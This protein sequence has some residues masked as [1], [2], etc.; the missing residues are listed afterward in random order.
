MKIPLK[1]LA[2]PML[3][4][5]IAALALRAQSPY[6][7]KDINAITA[8]SPA[9]SSPVNFFRYGSRVFFAATTFSGTELWSTDGTQAGTVQVADIFSASSSKPSRFVVVN[10]KLLF[11]ARDS[12]GEELWST[13]GTSAGTRLLADIFNGSQGSIPGDRIV[14][15]GQMIFSADDGVD[16]NEL[17]I[18][19]GTPAG[20]RF[21]KDL[22]PGADG[23][24]PHSFVLFNDT[25]YFVASGGLWKT[26][27]TVEGTVRVKSLDQVTNLLVAGSRMFFSGYTAQA[28]SGPWVSDG[29]EEG[30]RLIATVASATVSGGGILIGGSVALG[31]RYLFMA[32]EPQHGTELWISDG[33]TG[34]THPVRDINPGPTSSVSQLSIAV[35]G[36]I[37]IFSADTPSEGTELWRTDGTEAGTVL[38]RDILPG[39]SPGGTPFG[40]GPSSF[41]AVGDLVFFIAWNGNDRTLWTTDGTANGTHEVKTSSR[42]VF[43]LSFPVLTNID[44]VLYFAGANSLNGLEPWKSDGTDAGTSMIANIM[45][46]TAPSSVPL[47]L[48][49]AGDWIYFNAWD[50]LGTVTPE[51]GQPRSLWRSDGTPEGTLKLTDNP[52]TV[53]VPIGR[54]IFFNKLGGPDL[55][56]SDGTPEGTSLATEFVNRFPSTP[57]ILFVDGDRIFA[58]VAP[59]ALWTTTTAPKALA[60]SLPVSGAHGFADVAGRV[61]FFTDNGLWTS[62]GTPA[63]T[64]AIVPDLGGHGSSS[65]VFGGYLYFD[66]L[67]TGGTELWKSDGSFDG[68]TE[69]KT[70]LSGT[71]TLR[72]VVAGKNLFFIANGHLWI[73]DGTDAGTYALPAQTDGPIAAAGDHVLFP[74]SDDTNGIELWVSDGSPGG[75]HILRDI[76]PG[77]FSS[78][79]TE[80]TSVDG[81]VYFTASESVHGAE[82]WVT[83]GT[84]EGTKLVADL[85]PG[86][87]SSN[88]R[89]YIRAGD[90]LFF[91]AFTSATGGELWALALSSTPRLTV[92][93][94]R[95]A[96]GDSGTTTARFTVTLSAASARPVTVE[97]VTADGT[98]LAGSDYEAASGTLTFAPG[99][100]SKNIDILVRGDLIAENNETFAVT[101]RNAVGAALAKSS[102]FAIIDDDDGVADVSLALDFSSWDL[103]D[104]VVNATN[105]GP[106]TATNVKIL[107]TATPADVAASTCQVCAVVPQQLRSGATARVFDYRWFSYQQYLTATAVIHE[108]DPQPLNNSVGWVTN[109]YL[110]MDALYLTP[111][112]QANV[113][114]GPSANF[115]TVSI[116]SSDPAVVSV[117]SSVT[118]SLGKSVSF[119]AR[120]VTAGTATIRVFAP[121]ATVGTL[122]I[123]V[124]PAGTKPRWPGAITAYPENGGTSFDRQLGF[125]IYT[126]GT[127]PHSGET[128]T[129]V[130]TVTDN[131]RE[132][133]R[134]T[135]PPGFGL[136]RVLAYLPYLGANA[137]RIDYPGDASFL[138]MTATSNVTVTTGFATISGGAERNGTTAKVHLAVTG[139]PEGTPTGTIRISEPGVIPPTDLILTPASPGVAQADVILTNVSAAQHT[140]V[141]AYAGDT[142]YG[143]STQSV[144]LTETHK[145]AV[146]H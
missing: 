84:P 50:G 96:E 55:W 68:T 17:W 48:V 109:V 122:T 100:T 46:D 6:L 54:S 108:R 63:G 11:N 62:D 78:I 34:G 58:A 112:S 2:F 132:L 10:G 83:D 75:T 131:G 140:F 120:G 13:D 16:G 30:T 92:N 29:T 85:E 45:P 104:V 137:I 23:S 21:F 111:G 99:E 52:A 89:S 60:I 67:G 101:L 119:V 56:T 12:H 134:V 43:S 138:P 66:T 37:A 113:W 107:H 130:V 90:R 76:L 27:G 124:V 14:Y 18:T 44:G 15:H 123:D 8:S 86:L 72:F 24:Y 81:M 26:D 32:S 121:T 116:T 35:M 39:S 88:P 94:I 79:P 38:V 65:V 133:G 33:T 70:V 97:Y 4:S 87:S 141:I 40:S 103:L 80:L 73:T 139:S 22:A 93:D 91:T 144:R 49:A 129:G 110:A 135:L 64:Y 20:T 53:Y 59:G 117:P 95:V 142:H 114:V 61:M 74:S 7:V 41:V 146:R 42:L 71:L 106:R 77:T 31:D 145:R 5:L 28:G 126:T 105:N 98:A 1:R 115:T 47:N 9:A 125:S 19:D 128:A 36:D 102:G 118:L 127:A 3:L 25:V 82:P 136:K 51:G 57:S 143:P 69:I